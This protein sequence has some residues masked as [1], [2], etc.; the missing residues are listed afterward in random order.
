MECNI[1]RG[2]QAKTRWSRHSGSPLSA[3]DAFPKP[4]HDPAG[5][6]CQTAFRQCGARTNDTPR[7]G[8]IGAWAATHAQ[9][10]S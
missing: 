1:R 5:L 8:C 7:M 3:N 2:I 4:H 10:V 6:V 9:W